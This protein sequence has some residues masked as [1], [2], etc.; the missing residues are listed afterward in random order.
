MFALLL[1]VF[2]L[3]AER[4]AGLAAAQGTILSPANASGSVLSPAERLQLT[5][6]LARTYRLAGQPQ[7]ALE[8]LAQ[9]S[10]GRWPSPALEADYHDEVA[11]DLASLGRTREAQ[12]ELEKAASL[13]PTA[14]RRFRLSQLDERL[15][16]LEEARHE[17]DTA[18]ADEPRN[19]DYKAALAYLLRTSGDLRGAARLLSE[20]LAAKP[21][22]YTLHEDLG[23]LY[24]GLGEN[25]KAIEQFK[26]VIDNQQLYPRETEEERDGL[27]RRIEGLRQTI[28]AVEP[29][30]TVYGYTNLCLTGRYCD[31]RFRALESLISTNQGGLEV[32]YQPP[33]IGFVNGR[34]FQPFARAF[35][36]YA[37]G[38]IHPQGNSFQ[39]GAGIHYKPLAD[40]NLVVSGERL[41]KLGAN[42]INNW[43]GRISFSTSAGYEID[44]VAQKWAYNL[45]YVDLAGTAQSPHQ[46]LAY[47][48]GR[49]GVSFKLAD[50]FAISPFVYAIFRG[51]YGIGAN[52]SAETGIGASL[53]GFFDEDRYHSPRAALELLPRLG[54]TVYDSLAPTS[55][56]FSITIVA[57]F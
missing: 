46:A 39:G 20:V 35:W 32:D 7:T 53:R 37:P 41:I 28:N 34:T 25:G 31:R 49:D 8:T 27:A 11:R 50:R 21:Q 26:W 10:A 3:L 30:W 19:T 55:V 56:V 43:E 54:Y 18:L 22:R 2:S 42:A 16:E 1:P 6:A 4:N 33:D 29:H 24:L 40:Y 15:G 38:T 51:N 47:V 36:N 45:L 12:S 9:L 57:R 23:Y 13:E 52:T 48:D 14:E 44:P 17:L 5:L